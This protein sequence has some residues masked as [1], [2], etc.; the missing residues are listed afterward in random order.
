MLFFK[1]MSHSLLY[2]GLIFLL[3]K[4]FS[5]LPEIMLT[6]PTKTYCAPFAGSM[7]DVPVDSFYVVI[8]CAA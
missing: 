1:T 3:I 7:V 2:R 4:T 8:S 5:N 6:E